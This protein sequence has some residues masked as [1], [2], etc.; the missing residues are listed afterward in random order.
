MPRE[1]DTGV[2]RTDLR[3]LVLAVRARLVSELEWPAERV[4]VV[5]EDEHD[6]APHG[7]QLLELRLGDQE[8]GKEREGAGRWD[9]RVKRKVTLTLWTRV[10]LDEPTTDLILLT[11]RTLGHL[12]AELAVCDALEGWTPTNQ[13]GLDLCHE[14]IKVRGVGKAEKPKRRPGWAR[15]SFSFELH[16]TLALSGLDKFPEK[17]P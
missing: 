5:A 16:Y 1:P 8:W 11:D 3:T 2:P 14:E 4:L 17:L 12:A 9:Q 15:S 6:Y 10:Q 7:D 13:K